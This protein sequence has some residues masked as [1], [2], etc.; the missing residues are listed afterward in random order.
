MNLRKTQ[1]CNCRVCA[2]SRE[3][4]AHITALPK[5]HREY[6][7]GLYENYTMTCVDLNHAN[8]IIDG[9][10]PQADGVI[11]ASRKKAAEHKA[12]RAQQAATLPSAS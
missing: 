1:M 2:E 11:A 9:S 5:E 3:I 12:T 6:F 10:W 7:Q 4:E 8:A